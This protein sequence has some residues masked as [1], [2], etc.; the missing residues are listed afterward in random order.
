V[1]DG[2]RRG[3]APR[4]IELPLG[5]HAVSFVD[6]AGAAFGA[7]SVDVRPECSRTSP[8]VVDVTAEATR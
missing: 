8:K 5:R 3:F 2:L 4:I 1:I 7:R 6:E